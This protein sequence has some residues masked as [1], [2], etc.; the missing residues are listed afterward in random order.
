[1]QL[2]Q[3]PFKLIVST[4]SKFLN[5][6]FNLTLKYKVNARLLENVFYKLP[7]TNI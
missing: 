3:K 7:G 6:K 4:I 2:K 5:R 1:M